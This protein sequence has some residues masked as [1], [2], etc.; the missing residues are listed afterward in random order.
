M[1]NRKYLYLLLFIIPIIVFFVGRAYSIEQEVSSV[2]IQSDNYNQAGSWHIDKSAKWTDHGK[3]RITFDVNSIKKKVTN[4]KLDVVMVLDIS[5]SMGGEKL[6]REKT[7]AI[8]LV[9]YLITDNSDNRIGLI[10]FNSDSSI[11][12]G[13]TDDKDTLI[14]KLNHLSIDG[15]TN[16]NS[17]LK[18]VDV[19]LENYEKR[20]DTDLVVLFLTDGYPNHDVPNEKATYQLLKEKYPYMVINGIQ[21]EM[22]KDIIQD[23]ID[24]TDNQW[25]A[26]K[27]SLHNVLFDAA[28]EVYNYDSFVITDYIDDEY[29]Y[30]NSIDDIHVDVGE[31]SLEVENGVQKIIWN[32]GDQYKTRDNIK[33]Y[34]DVVLKETYVGTKGYYPTNKSETIVSKLL[35]EEQTVNSNLTPVLKS[36]Y[37]VIYDINA[38][39]Y[40]YYDSIPNEEH[41]VYENVTKRNDNFD[42]YGYTF[43]GWEI[44][45]EDKEDMKIINDDLFVMP[46]HDVHLRGIWSGHDLHKSMD[47]TVF[48]KTTL[49][50]VIQNDAKNTTY[51]RGYSGA[52]KDS[53]TEPATM[54][55]YYYTSGS[56]AVGKVLKENKINVLFANLCWQMIRTTD[57]GGVKLIYNGEPDNGTCLDTRSSHPGYNQMSNTSLSGN[58]YYGTDY[59]YDKSTQTFKLSGTLEQATWNNSTY[60]N[61]IGKYTCKNTSA[62]GTCTTLYLVVDY[63]SSSSAQ[64]MSIVK[65]ANYATYGTTKYNST[66][67]SPSSVG[68][69]YNAEYPTYNSGHNTTNVT[70]SS[71]NPLNTSYW[72]G[73]GITTDGT[74]YTLTNPFKVSS[75]SDYP[76]LV[77]KYTMKDADA[78]SGTTVYYISTVKNQ[79]AFYIELNDGHDLAYNNYQIIYG[80][81]VVKN[82]DGTFSISNPTTVNRTEFYNVYSSLKDKYVCVKQGSVQCNSFTDFS[83]VTASGEGYITIAN[84]IRFFSSGYE[85]NELTGEYVLSDDVVVAHEWYDPNIGANLKDNHYTCYSRTQT[86]CSTLLY[87]YT[88]GGFIRLTGGKTINQELQEMLS[89]NTDTYKLNKKDSVIK[90]AVEKWYEKFLLKYDDYIEDTIYCNDRSIRSIGAFDPNGGRVQYPLNFNNYVTSISSYAC[91]ND[92]DQFSTM[93]NN[94]KLKYKVGLITAPELNNGGL[95]NTVRKIGTY[96]WTMSPYTFKYDLNYEGFMASVDSNGKRISSSITKTYGLR[97]VI[98]LVPNIEYIEGDG[99]MS[100][101]YKIDTSSVD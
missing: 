95:D 22:G 93:N 82:N 88:K 47:G 72:Y 64:V 4:N 6:E 8:G 34:I 16:Y 77:G 79:S 36:Y 69:M 44:I 3:A 40:C 86:S 24:I 78:T 2:E 1:K 63:Y 90:F 97:P 11:C 99:S 54:Q 13:L 30:V 32:L 43:N 70:I 91:P 81:S 84:D 5:G 12:S 29:F 67:S 100:N 66:Y 83:Y 59:T 33:M 96:Y 46:Y 25:V 87:I 65:F 15:D 98:S 49:Y 51:A 10:V 56:Q 21:Y 74:T 42:C 23:I 101:P 89:L 28:E 14:F 75:T 48:V 45:D 26:D 37:N 20:D 52:H 92:L 9:N 39:Y 53:Y 85:Y 18:N 73:D 62:T 80:N 41:V 17:A 7:D 60:T 50:K 27:T 57:T 76:D 19:V 58:Y 55:I 35:D 94:A 71:Y 61:L 38:P 68:Y 31:V